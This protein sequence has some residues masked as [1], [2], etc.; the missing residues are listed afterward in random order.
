M[1]LRSTPIIT[2]SLDISKSTCITNF[3]FCRAAH[4]AASFTRF[5]R[6]APEKPGVPRAMMDN[7]TSSASG[8]LRVCTRR[9]SSRP[10]TSGRATTTRRSNRPGRSKAGSSTSGRFVA[11][12]KITPSFDSNP[13]ISTSKAFKVCSLSSCPPPSPAPRCRPTASISS[14]K[15]MQGAFFFPC[16]NKSR[17][18]LAPTPTNIST[19]SEPEIEKNGTLA[20]PAIALASKVLPVPGGPTSST[21]FGIRPPSFWNFCGS[22]RNSIIS[23]NS[24]FASSVPATSLNVAFFCCAESNRARDF[25]KLSAL[26]PPA[27]ICRIKNRQKPTSKIKG[28]AFSKIKIQSPLRTS[29]IPLIIAPLS[30]NCFTRSGAASLKTVTTNFWFWGRRYSPW[31][32]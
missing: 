3:R 16:S 15:I 8:T 27:C 20:S 22:F 26:F 28:A 18:R 29:F 2:L 31:I 10:L 13:S 17:T 4:N 11:A 6:S 23:C 21:P 12:I 1:H 24:S 5:A 19:K 14:I 32:S 7:S 25:P 9:I 30:F